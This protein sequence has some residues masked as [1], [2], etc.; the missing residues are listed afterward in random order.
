MNPK[1]AESLLSLSLMVLSACETGLG[2]TRSGDGVNELRRGLLPA[3][4]RTQ[5]ALLW[6]VADLP[7]KDL[8]VNFYRHL[9][10]G[11]GRSAALRRAQNEMQAKPGQSHP[12]YWASFVT[13]GDWTALD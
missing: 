8:M 11:A 5:V 1:I 12:Y 9:A 3:G 13:I 10:Q 7:T 4:A 2:E 6:E